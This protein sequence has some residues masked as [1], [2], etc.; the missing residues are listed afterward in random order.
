MKF[1]ISRSDKGSKAR[2]GVISFPHCEIDTPVFMPVGTQ[3]TVKGLVPF[4][5]DQAGVQM[6]VSNTYHLHIRPGEK[7]VEKGGG[8]H[9][10]MN[11]HKGILTDSGGF[12]VISLANLRKISDEGV[13]FQ[14]HVDG[15]TIFFTP[16]KVIEIQLALGA[17][18]IMSFDEPA[19]YPSPET[20]SEK[21][22]KRTT[23]WGR[24]G[25][26][27]FVKREIGSRALFGIV[28]GGMYRKLR[29]RSSFELQDIGFDGYAIGGLA[30]GEPKSTQREVTEYTARLLPGDKP[31]YL[32]GVGYPED[33]ID[34]VA[35]GIDMFDCV[36]PTRNARTGTVFTSRG[37]LVIKN[38]PCAED[39]LPIDSECDCY[40][41]KHFSRAYI[42]HLFNVGEMLGPVLSTIHN[43]S[44]FMNLMKSIRESID[45][46]EFEKWT[47]SFLSKYT[48][49][50]NNCA[51]SLSS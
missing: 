43:V 29:E 36:I 15:S 35:K 12:Q 39:N 9:S 7:I 23:D 16:E 10:F 37:K 32:M 34:A 51:I 48:S 13:Q 44:F 14:S 8:L 31:R 18:I 5:L 49:S 19:L 41:C 22:V 45:R 30:I 40:V 28:Q 6:I 21:S 47:C 50:E 1:T 11:W 46:N 24:R 25:K 33:I 20:V 42:R 27:V 26:E 3:G 2:T 38:A 4:F 17:D